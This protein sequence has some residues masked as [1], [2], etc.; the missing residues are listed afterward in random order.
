MN[1][2][3]SMLSGPTNTAELRSTL[4]RRLNQKSCL[5]RAMVEPNCDKVRHG[6]STTSEPGLR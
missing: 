1:I 3:D 2:A 5:C 6:R 4:A